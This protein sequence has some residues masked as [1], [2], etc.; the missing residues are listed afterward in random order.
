MS[1]SKAG[2]ESDAA[3]LLDRNSSLQ[4]STAAGSGS[5]S[6]AAGQGGSR[7]QS[8]GNSKGKGKL[9]VTDPADSAP[10]VEGGA[11][12]TTVTAAEAGV[13]LSANSAAKQPL[14][15]HAGGGGGGS[16]GGSGGDPPIPPSPSLWPSSSSL[17]NAASEQHPEPINPRALVSHLDS[18]VVGQAKAKKV[19]SVAVYNH[20]L[21]IRR[22]EEREMWEDRKAEAEMM[23]D[24][25][26]QFHRQASAREEQSAQVPAAGP[27]SQ[28]VPAA[29]A[30]ANAKSSP[31]TAAGGKKGRQ[32]AKEAGETTK[33]ARA[34]RTSSPTLAPIAPA[35]SSVPAGLGAVDVD[36]KTQLAAAAA[37][38]HQDVLTDYIG[39]ASGVMRDSRGFPVPSLLATELPLKPSVEFFS[40]HRPAVDTPPA[41]AAPARTKGK[42]GKA[43][44]PEVS[45]RYDVS[46]DTNH[47]PS[48][49]MSVEDWSDA[50]PPQTFEK[51]NILLIGPTG[52]GKT[53]LMK[54]LAEAL[55]VPYVHI[56][57]SPLT[58]A[59][60]VGEDVEVIGHR[61]L[62]AAGWD[63]SRAEQGIVCIDE[64][65]SRC[66]CRGSTC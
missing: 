7:A 52:S 45:A 10:E 60:Y 25:F 5:P 9:R 34:A 3:R 36:E 14:P 19:L 58:Q 43:V 40:S 28:V 46:S 26:H 49:S 17:L 18:Y 56:D 50:V 53:L 66:L 54:S 37:R 27:Q 20:Y 55:Q 31:T 44:A 64:I 51:S 11:H 2:G 35:A 59:G 30:A 62:A 48:S 57:A 13:S 65:V 22:K 63:L 38:A 24:Q 42:A 29:T 41:S 61:L 39:Q 12:L 15:S 8:G 23:A 47:Q 32:S 16:S 21:R 1:S 6:G 33:S 4:S